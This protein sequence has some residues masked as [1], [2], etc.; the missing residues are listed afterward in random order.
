MN[1]AVQIANRNK[2]KADDRDLLKELTALKFALDESAIVAFTDRTGKIIY[3]NDKFCEIS[4]Y[5]REELIGQDHRIINSGFHSKE[6]IRNLWTTIANGKVW[7]GEIRNRA[8]DGSI[9][10][11]DTT[12]VPFLDEHGKPYQYAA[13]R[14]D[15]TERKKSEAQIR[16]MSE[17]LEQTY[18]A[19][20]R[21]KPNEGI[22][23]W[24]K[25]AERLYGFAKEEALGKFPPDL[26]QTVYPEKSGEEFLSEI[27]HKKFWEGELLH[28]TK[29]GRQMVV[30]AR[31]VTSDKADGK[32][33]VLETT[34]DITSRKRAEERIRQQA[35]LLDK[36]SDAILV[37][38]LDFKIIYWNQGAERLYGWRAEE[39]L[40]KEA[41][42]VLCGGD[43]L[44]LLEAKK[45]LRQKEEWNTEASHVTKSG[46][47]LTVES[48][49][50]LIHEEK[51]EPDYILILNTD[52]TR[53]KK[54]EEQLLRA[55]RMES[56]GTLAGGIAHDLNN[57]LAP[58]MMAIKIL[59]QQAQDES[60][61]KWLSIIKENA[62]RGADL[63]RQVLSFSRGVEGKRA[64]VQPRH[65][66][67]DL[68]KILSE[69]FPKS[70]QIK[71]DLD[72]ELWTIFADPT[73]IHQ[74]L[75]NLAINAR[76]AMPGGGVL[77]LTAGN[78]TLDESYALMNIEAKPG[79]YVLLTVAD[80]GRGMTPEIR[81]RIFDP[82]FTT[83]KIGEGTG[84]GL[85]TTLSIVKSHGGFINVYSESGKG[86]KFSIYLPAAKSGK[87]AE[88]NSSSSKLPRGKGETILVVDDEESI[89]KITRAT[90]EK[91]GYRILTAANGAEA[92][93]VYAER[94]GEISLVL[95]DIAMPFMD[96]I[97]EIRALRKLNPKIKVIAASGL[98]TA[99]Q[100]AELQ[101]LEINAFLSKPYT[102]EKLLN[103]LAETLQNG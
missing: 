95:T 81:E 49:W 16:E 10:W 96:G 9:Y 17:L 5:E 88:K 2:I 84:L 99:E 74:V 8:K 39:V 45:T 13:I 40:G 56:I 55:Q 91:F 73:Q 51:G 82:F 54:T 85:A 3:V 7:R 75:M 42:D 60:S 46:K 68:I 92:L 83:K 11:V 30:E 67:L 47:T 32:F 90:L 33:S 35:S 29:D 94:R 48:R 1:K 4:R 65:L 103:T 27:K 37:C 71:F 50:T 79:D 6:F 59:Q 98:T 24:N 34:R 36:A 80:T 100:S 97:A 43:R 15:I 41:C 19:I 101:S 53:Q 76:D 12:V 58:I 93:A 72:P 57:I 89:L 44:Q 22:V 78:E 69:T 23:Y 31:I 20:F 77:T 64:C 63:V 61:E 70:I 38:D 102:A 86:S 14:Y 87:A 18:D 25:S 62:R 28:T 66:I 52:V 21:W 26:L